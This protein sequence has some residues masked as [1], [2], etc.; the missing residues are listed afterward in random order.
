M[1]DVNDNAGKK[2]EFRRLVM[3]NVGVA[4][5]M[6]STLLKPLKQLRKLAANTP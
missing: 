4:V 1:P 6:K 3:L 5:F 2:N